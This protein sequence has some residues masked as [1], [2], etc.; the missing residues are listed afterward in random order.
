KTLPGAPAL[1][2]HIVQRCLEKNPEDRW[3]TAHDLLIQLRWLAEG[4][5]RA[6]LAPTRKMDRLTRVLLAVA[7]CLILA[8]AVP[9]ALYLRGSAESGPLQFRVPVRGLNTSDIALSPDGQAI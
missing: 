2:Q 9:A 4:D 7:A 1:L 8:L 3:Q 5:G 6:A